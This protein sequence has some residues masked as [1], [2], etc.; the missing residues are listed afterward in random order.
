MYSWVENDDLLEKNSYYLGQSQC[1][2][3][4]EFNSKSVYNK[5]FLKTKK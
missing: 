2:Y 3:K 5:T 4:K 1:W